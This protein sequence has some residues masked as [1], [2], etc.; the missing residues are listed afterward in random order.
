MFPAVVGCSVDRDTESTDRGTPSVEP[1][2][3]LPALRERR[4]PR[5]AEGVAG[6]AIQPEFRNVAADAGVTFTFHTDYVPDRYF[7]PEIM[8]GGVGCLDYDRDGNMDLFFPNGSWLIPDSSES[9]APPRDAFYRNLS[10]GRQFEQVSAETGLDHPAYGQGCA[11]ADYDADGFPDLYLTNYGDNVLYHNNGDGTFSIVESD[12]LRGRQRWSTSCAW[13]D[14]NDDGWIDL[15]VVNYLN[16]TEQNLQVCDYNGIPGYCGP[17]KFD[18]LDDEVFLNLG[19]GRFEE[20]AGRLG[21][22]AADGKGLAVSVLDFDEDL[23]PEVYVANDMTENFLFSRSRIP[24]ASTDSAAETPYLN[25]GYLSGSAVSEAGMNE[26]SMGIAAAD[27]D[28]DGLPDIYLTH[29]YHQKNTLYHNR[30]GLTFYDDSRRFGVTVHSHN[31]LGFGVV[32]LDFDS[33]G[34]TDLFIA[35]GH[36][37][38]PNYSPFEMTPQL[39]LNLDGRG[40]EDISAAAGDYFR[41]EYLGRGAAGTDF[42]NDGDADIVVSHLDAPAA[43]LRNETPPD[44]GAAVG[45]LLEDRHR[46]SPIGGRV[47]VEAGDYRRTYPIVSGG[48]YLSSPDPRLLIALPRSLDES[49]LIRIYWTSGAVSEHTDLTPGRYWSIREGLDPLPLASFESGGGVSGRTR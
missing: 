17:G 20:A 21:F 37:I 19:D 12:V 43:L 8:G 14:V 25:L 47:E 27:F 4:S 26:A 46:Q 10:Q 39:L 18:A 44:G 1:A 6:Q 38:G 41:G 42:D 34:A 2:R 31:Y 9:G 16:V 5:S 13:V 33:D 36:V 32:P 23:R 30:G 7:L 49:A 28:V 3:T 45:L 40:F 48:S 22:I 11:A 29:Y 35:N 15:Y 24:G